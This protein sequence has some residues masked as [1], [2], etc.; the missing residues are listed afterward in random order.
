MGLSLGLLQVFR[1]RYQT[2]SNKDLEVVRVIT[3]FK[4][5]L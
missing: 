2:L 3:A 1:V 4:A 5:I